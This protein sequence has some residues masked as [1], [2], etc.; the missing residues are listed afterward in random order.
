MNWPVLRTVY[1]AVLI[2]LM[3]CTGCGPRLARE[4]DP[5]CHPVTGNV[6][7]KGKPAQYA[8]VT[9]TPVDVS[10]DRLGADGICD[11][12]GFFRLQ[13]RR[14]TEGAEPGDYLV[15]ISWRIPE[16]PGSDDP[17][18]G[19]ELLPKK[20]LDKSTSGLKF[21]VEPTENEV[22]PYDLNP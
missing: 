4:A 2:S 13:T 16:R 22:P 9:F 18:Y 10:E 17:E 19:K 1:S 21:T 12:D 7:F 3:L 5:V 11:E 20:Y 14:R 6:T 15:T 8:I